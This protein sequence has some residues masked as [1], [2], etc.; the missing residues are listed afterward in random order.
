MDLLKK[1]YLLVKK[2]NKLFAEAVDKVEERNVKDLFNIF[3]KKK[4]LDFRT[5]II[6]AEYYNQVT[7]RLIKE[8][9]EIIKDEKCKLNK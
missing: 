9:D 8:L 7:G 4:R 6:R 2:Y 1:Q 3:N 5:E